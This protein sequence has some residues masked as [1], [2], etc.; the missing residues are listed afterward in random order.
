MSAQLQKTLRQLRNTRELRAETLDL[1]ARIAGTSAAGRM[2]VVDPVISAA[3]I[4]EEWDRL[5]PALAPKV[6]A[7]MTLSIEQGGEGAAEKQ[8]GAG[9]SG[10]LPLERPNYR[11]E[12]LRLLL[13][14]SLEGDGPQSANGIAAH[15]GDTQV[16]LVETLGASATPVR[17]A[18]V[19]LRNA[20][21]IRSLRWL[22]IAP[23]TLSMEQLSRLGAL[24]QTLRFR[25]ERGA[26]I[27][28]PA[29]LAERVMPLLGANGPKSWKPFSLSGTPVASKD[30][31]GLDLLGT[32]RLDL[33]AHAPRGN[34]VFDASV[35]RMLDDGLEPEPN[36]L[37]PAPV[38]VTLVRAGTRFDR[39]AEI[40][41]A[42]CAHPCDVF[43]SLLDLG[44]RE[45]ALQYAKAVRP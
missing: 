2:T 32:P 19:A 40:D 38:V 25:F 34:K 8:I 17:S 35:M 12:V 13:G 37:A 18:L 41:H 22:E 4:Q 44:L 16:G 9:E 28:S 7:R 43:L 39:G 29:E 26:R 23:E 3:A 42:R 31:P 33:V 15:L 36:V 24:P 1:A 20:S 14:A 10:L 30:A 27:K 5:L 6:R 11:F 21:L 45:Q